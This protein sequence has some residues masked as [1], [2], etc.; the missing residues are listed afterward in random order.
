MQKSQLLLTDYL[1]V[2][3]SGT[4]V[5]RKPT[6][7]QVIGRE[8]KHYVPLDLLCKIPKTSELFGKFMT[9]LI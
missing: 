9:D 3:K 6:R 7:L 1:N 2:V 4:M 8:E 5:E